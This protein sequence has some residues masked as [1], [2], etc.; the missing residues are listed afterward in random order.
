MIPQFIDILTTF[1]LHKKA[2]PFRRTVALEINAS[3]TL[4]IKREI[5]VKFTRTKSDS[6]AITEVTF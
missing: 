1:C 4:F 2:P 5:V 3:M 6:G